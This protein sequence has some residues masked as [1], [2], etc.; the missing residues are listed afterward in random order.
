MGVEALPRT[1]WW[2]VDGVTGRPGVYLIDQTRLPLV[3]DILCCATADAVCTVIK[4]LA[5]RGAPA[6]GVAA[7]LALAVWS[8]NESEQTEVGLY[9]D[10]LDVVTARVA[11]TRPTAVNLSWGAE[12]ACA[13][14]HHRA[15]EGADLVTIKAEL[16]GLA[17]RMCEED[18]DCNRR[19]GAHGAALLDEGSN[20]LTHCN[21]GSLATAFY[22]TALGV[23]YTA[24][25]QGRVAHVWVDETRPVNQ[26]GRLTAWEL[27][28]AGV[29]ATLICDN[30][31][32]S[33]MRAG[34]VDAVVVGADRICANG[35]TANKIGTYGV[36]VLAHEHHIPFYVAAP[37]STV[38]PLLASGDAIVIEQRDPREVEGVVASGTITPQG[39]QVHALDLLT[40]KGPCE[41][42][43]KGGQP[44]TITRK[45]GGYTFDGWFKRTPL[46][47]HVYNPA[48]DVTPSHYISGIITEVGVFT[49]DEQGVYALAHVH[50][51]AAQ[52]D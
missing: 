1:I 50:E 18:E 33:I 36:A 44:F 2:D 15:E 48:F 38:D 45:G 28:M 5:V 11:T 22:G 17:Q 20:V 13:F 14:A 52:K 47:V 37:L 41:L 34:A 39:D 42:A 3:G 49:P 32:A 12:R 43:V 30:M 19:I 24:F 21:A 25:E 27:G 23:V 4:S 26:G 10:A 7:A 9:L 8:E 46:G 31:A 6:L 29:P 16:V 35:D 40:E 51:D